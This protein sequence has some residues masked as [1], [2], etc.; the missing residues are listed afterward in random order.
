MSLNEYWQNAVKF[1]RWIYLC[2]FGFDP[3]RKSIFEDGLEDKP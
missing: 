3:N 2:L 1:F